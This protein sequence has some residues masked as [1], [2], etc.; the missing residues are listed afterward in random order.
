M[1]IEFLIEDVS[2]AKMLELLLPKILPAACSYKVH[3]YKGIGGRIPPGFKT[4]PEAAQHRI[5]LDNLPKLLSGYGKTFHD[6]GANYPAA[7]VV[8][9]DLDR[10]DKNSFE[11]E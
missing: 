3:S 5:L 2:T 1:H 10:R 8:V 9:C 4:N 6:Y 11:S 7:V